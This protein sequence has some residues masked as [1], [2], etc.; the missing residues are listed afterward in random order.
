MTEILAGRRLDTQVAHLV[1]GTPIDELNRMDEVPPYSRYPKLAYAALEHL[2]T[3][4][5]LQYDCY[6]PR[7]PGHGN[8]YSCLISV[9]DDA[10]TFVR[11][12]WGYGRT[13]A[14]SICDA[15][16]E[17]VNWSPEAAGLP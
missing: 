5:R 13:E 6:G 12:H 7:L 11:E 2:K 4:I 14:M 1:F 3:R 16:L 10:G 15:A 9:G 17:V 8:S